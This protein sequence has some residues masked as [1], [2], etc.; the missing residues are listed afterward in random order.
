MPLVLLSKL[1]AARGGRC[2]SERYE[3]ALTPLLWKC[4]AGHVWRA[5]PHSVRQGHW[6]G[7]CA[8]ERRKLKLETLRGIA[9][10][11]GGACLARAYANSQTRVRW[12]CAE[13]HEWLAIP[14]AVKRGAWC[15]ACYRERKRA[16]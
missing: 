3:G 16:A 12:R 8:N 4:S 7:R 1:A 13:G 10:A 5:T 14:N 15:L 11:R 6:C 9:A 2:L